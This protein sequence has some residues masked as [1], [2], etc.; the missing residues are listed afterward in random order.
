MRFAI[1]NGGAEIRWRRRTAVVLRFL[2]KELRVRDGYVEVNLVGARVMKKNVLSYEA[3]RGFARPDV[4]SPVLGEIYLNP[5]YIAKRGENFDLM[6]VHGFLHLLG[7]DHKRKSDRIK[8][9]AKECA[10][11]SRLNRKAKTQK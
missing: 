7:Y 4:K 8:M 9:E 6:L 11:L 1:T 10:L 2:A 5:S 3:P